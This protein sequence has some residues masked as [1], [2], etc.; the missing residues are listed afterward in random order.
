MRNHPI[1]VTRPDAQM[2]RALL[3]RRAAAS[4]QTGLSIADQKFLED[5]DFELERAVVSIRSICRRMS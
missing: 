4:A 3:A 5:L 2:L 1:L